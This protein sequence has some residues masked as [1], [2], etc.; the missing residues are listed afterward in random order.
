MTPFLAQRKL[1]S[2]PHYLASQYIGRGLTSRYETA[3]GELVFTLRHLESSSHKPLT[4][5]ATQHGTLA[6]PTSGLETWLNQL[7]SL[8]YP[9]PLSTEDNEHAWQYELYCQHIYPALQPLLIPFTTLDN[10]SEIIEG[11]WFELIWQ[12]NNQHGSVEIFTIPAT[13]AS[14]LSSGT[15]QPINELD[16]ASLHCSSPLTLGC[17]ANVSALEQGDIVMLS[18]TYFSPT[19]S[20]AIS[21]AG[22]QV[23]IE[24]LSSGTQPQYQV[25]QVTTSSAFEALRTDMNAYDSD[26]F[27]SS[28]ESDYDQASSSHDAHLTTSLKVVAGQITLTLAELRQ[29]GPGSVLLPQGEAAGFASLFHGSTRIA[30]GEIVTVEGQLGLQVT[31]VLLPSQTPSVNT[32]DEFHSDQAALDE[33]AEMESQAWD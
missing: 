8:P 13:I 29:L 2:T 19:G 9:A 16:L 32:S 12:H 5:F 15:W 18:T 3:L 33:S 14:W 25:T 10:P 4:Y 7:S 28:Y 23:D 30:R 22:L 21:L 26:P 20:G 24:Y 27:H 6:L 31:E 1:I 11:Q 17:C